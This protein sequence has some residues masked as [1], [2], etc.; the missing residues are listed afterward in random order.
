MKNFFFI[1]VYSLFQCSLVKI[2]PEKRPIKKNLH[3]TRR[4]R[5]KVIISQLSNQHKISPKKKEE[6]MHCGKF[7][8]S[9]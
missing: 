8:I 3:I 1:D 2:T 6:E 5:K 9:S 7:Q 4:A